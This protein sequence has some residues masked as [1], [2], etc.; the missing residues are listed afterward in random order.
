MKSALDILKSDLKDD[1]YPLDCDLPDG[2][3]FYTRDR[4]VADDEKIAQMAGEFDPL[5]KTL[6]PGSLQTHMVCSIIRMVLDKEGQPIFD[7][8]NKKELMEKVSARTIQKI[9]MALYK[10]DQSPEEMEKN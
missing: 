4:T 7:W 2:L 5:T 9:Y 10:G 6:V 8:G 3:N 1:I